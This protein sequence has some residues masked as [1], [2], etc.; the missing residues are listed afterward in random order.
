MSLELL[1][2]E[3]EFISA[4][5]VKR[6][7]TLG[8]DELL[9]DILATCGCCEYDAIDDDEPRLATR[10]RASLVEKLVPLLRTQHASGLVKEKWIDKWKLRAEQYDHC[11]HCDRNPA[12]LFASDSS[13]ETSH[14]FDS[15]SE[16]EEDENEEESSSSSSDEDEA[17]GAN[18]SQEDDEAK[19]LKRAADEPLALDA[20]ELKR[21]KPT[22]Q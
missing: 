22:V 17:S 5:P 19:T 9:L 15:T 6:A 7:W 10:R 16:E 14:D 2:E 12:L 20:I 3:L 1:C 4:G 21:A 13:E 18:C 11:L 8:L